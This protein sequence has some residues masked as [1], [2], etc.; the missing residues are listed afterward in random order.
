MRRAHVDAIDTSFVPVL[1]TA[2]TK[3]GRRA[4]KLF[5]D[6]SPQMQVARRR[7]AKSLS[8]CLNRRGAM[9]FRDLPNA[10]GSVSR[11]SNL[12]CH[13]A[14]A[15]DSRRVRISIANGSTRSIQT[16]LAPTRLI[17]RHSGYLDF[18]AYPFY[19]PSGLF[20]SLFQP[21]RIQLMA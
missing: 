4:Y 16:H 19:T 9:F 7:I 11:A 8:D 15:S 3:K 18:T 12:S 1:K 13:Q 20:L 21:T 6:D 10:K 5:A 17:W 2:L 14:A